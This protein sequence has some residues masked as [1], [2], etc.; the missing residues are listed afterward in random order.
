MTRIIETILQPCLTPVSSCIVPGAKGW[1]PQDVRTSQE[2]RDELIVRLIEGNPKMS[3]TMILVKTKLAES[4]VRK[5]L[6]RMVDA[7][8]IELVEG[9]STAVSPRR[10]Y[11]IKEVMH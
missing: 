6:V 2:R 1:T 3:Q 10:F 9:D 4:T 5:A 11:K 7:G 8:R